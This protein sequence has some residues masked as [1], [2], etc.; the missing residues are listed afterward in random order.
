MPKT[1]WY[2][3]SLLSCL[4]FMAANSIN[5]SFAFSKEISKNNNSYS[6]AYRKTEFLLGE[7][8]SAIGNLDTRLKTENFIALAQKQKRDRK[9][10]LSQRNDVDKALDYLGAT[11]KLIH[12]RH[13]KE[14]EIAVL[15]SVAIEASQ[16]KVPSPELSKNVKRKLTQSCPKHS[17]TDVFAKCINILNA[18][19]RKQ[20]EKYSGTPIAFIEFVLKKVV[21]STGMQSKYLSKADLQDMRIQNAGSFGGLGIEV[22]M[23]D[24]YVKVIA[25]IDGSPAYQADI[26]S[27]D[28]ITHLDGKNIQ[29]W[30]LKKA[31]DNMRGEV[32][33]PIVLTVQRAQGLVQKIKIVRD[34][35]KVVPVKW[36]RENNVGYIRISHFSGLALEGVRSAVAELFFD[37]D[38]SQA[39]LIVDVRNTPGGLYN[40]VKSVSE[41]FLDGGVISSMRGPAPNSTYT[42]S[43]SP[44]DVLKGKPIVVLVN[45]GTASGAE[46]FAVALQENQRAKIVGTRTFGMG[47]QQTIFPISGDQGAVKIPT[48]YIYTPN[49]NIF[50]AVGLSPDEVVFQP[51]SQKK[52]QKSQDEER[53]SAAESFEEER[54]NASLKRSYYIPKDSKRDLQLQRALAIIRAKTGGGS[55]T[56]DETLDL[57]RL[58]E[59]D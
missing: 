20:I 19:F 30:T 47:H 33:S 41:E 31:V 53:L 6:I 38:N 10:S 21:V 57:K 22:T 5:S 11:L 39:G 40:A 35:I 12:E 29:G 42:Y 52:S 34:K 28:L 3:F 14:P 54:S 37:D 46:I 49:N 7:N 13:V 26:R 27:G 59:L 16:E 24:G 1:R 32:G 4:G 9:N 43:A 17:A 23:K 2:S 50:D 45:G 44:G 51:S 18:F 56:P 25:P 48:A 58:E 36:R 15:S 8:Y 55:I